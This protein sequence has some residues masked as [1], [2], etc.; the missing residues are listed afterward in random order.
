MCCKFNFRH[1]FIHVNDMDVL[2][3]YRL[4]NLGRLSLLP[5]ILRHLGREGS[6]AKFETFISEFSFFL[7]CSVQVRLMN[8]RY[9]YG[10]LDI[11]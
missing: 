8:G 10:L 3:F 11:D 2:S 7:G 9:V 4:P 1:I 5:A 6:L